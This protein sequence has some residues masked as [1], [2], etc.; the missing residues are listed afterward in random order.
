VRSIKLFGLA[1][2][3][4]GALMAFMGATS[5]MAVT[6]LE[7]VVFCKV[8]TSPCPNGKD[9]GAPTPFVAGIKSGTTPT[10]LTNA[11]NIKCVKSSE[12]EGITEE[13]RLL[14]DLTFFAWAGCSRNGEPCTVTAEH[15]QYRLR[16]ELFDTDTGYRFLAFEDTKGPPQLRLQCEMGLNCAISV[17]TLEMEQVAELSDAVLRVEEE[18]VPGGFLCVGLLGASTVVHAEYLLRCF[19]GALVK[20]CW[21]T[22]E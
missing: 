1:T 15:L 7:K 2:L 8:N 12:I 16:G 9:F 17:K 22:M 13:L 14:G 11:G 21:M 6:E 5:A 4:I 10:I 20:N 18:F 3:A 19:E